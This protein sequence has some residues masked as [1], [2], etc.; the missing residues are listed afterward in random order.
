MIVENPRLS[1]FESFSDLISERFLII[2]IFEMINSVIKSKKICLDGNI[3][4]NEARH[5][6]KIDH[7]T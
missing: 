3:V 4:S 7:A 5:I 6:L 2:V 1:K